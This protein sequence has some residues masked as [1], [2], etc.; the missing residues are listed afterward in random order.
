MASDIGQ[1][2]NAVLPIPG[3]RGELLDYVTPTLVDVWN[4]AP[5]NHDGKFAS[6]LHGITPCNTLLDDCDH[7][8]A[9]KNL[10]DQHG[11]TSSLTPRQIRLL[12]KFLRAPHNA[13]ASGAVTLAS[14]IEAKK[15]E[16]RASVEAIEEGAKFRPQKP[17]KQTPER[18]AEAEQNLSQEAQKRAR[19]SGLD[20]AVVRRDLEAQRQD[21]THDV[22]TEDLPGAPFFR[23]VDEG[24]T[25]VLYLNVAHPFYTELYQGPG[26]SPRLR[27]G[28]EIVLWALGEAEAN[29]DPESDRRKFYERDRA[30]LWTPYIAD[31][32]AALKTIA[33][34]ETE[35]EQ[36]PDAVD[37]ETADAVVE[38][39]ADAA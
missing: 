18:E 24:G 12:E 37:D 29:A 30:S 34:V 5:F 31:A 13:T 28:L 25:R 16:Q 2:Q 27:A 39:D 35:A 10:N 22:D 1:F 3:S 15:D 11:S 20:A 38:E 26:S 36:D 21:R 7:P 8:D 9:G 6:L 19:K 17:P 23:C 32:L 33:V 14:E 4:T